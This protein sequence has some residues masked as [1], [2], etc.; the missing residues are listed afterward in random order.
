MYFSEWINATISIDKEAKEARLFD[1]KDIKHEYDLKIRS[2]TT[3]L[4]ST[5]S[6]YRKKGELLLKRI[7]KHLRKLESE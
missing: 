7:S 3:P 4:G 6:R 5:V 2:F 1:L